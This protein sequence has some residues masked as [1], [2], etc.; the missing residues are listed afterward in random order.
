MKEKVILILKDV[1]EMNERW[2]RRREI[3]RLI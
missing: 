2:K 3:L 1:L